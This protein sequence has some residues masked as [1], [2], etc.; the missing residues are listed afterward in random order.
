MYI[1]KALI[2][3]RNIPCIKVRRFFLRDFVMTLLVFLELKNSLEGE[4]LRGSVLFMI[5]KTP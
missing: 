4:E 3:W 2:M 5:M 1:I